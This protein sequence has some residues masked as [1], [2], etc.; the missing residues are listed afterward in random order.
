V[1]GTGFVYVLDNEGTDVAGSGATS[2]ILPF[3]VGKQ[4]LLQAQTGGVVADDPPSPTHLPAG[5]IP[6]QVLY[7]ANQGNNVQGTS[8]TSGLSGYVIDPSTHQLSFIA[9]EPFGP[10]QVRNAWLKTLPTSSVTRP[11][12]TIPP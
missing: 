9:G 4:R 8:P 5:R 11:T 3:T 7:V 10:V 6:R 12:S 1:N 2:Q